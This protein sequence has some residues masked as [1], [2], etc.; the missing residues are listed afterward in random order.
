MCS[1]EREGGKWI[2][3]NANIN[4]RQMAA[5]FTLSIAKQIEAGL[6]ASGKFDGSHACLALATTGGNVLVHSPH[7]Q[8]KPD[9][10]MAEFDHVQNNDRRLAWTGELAELQIGNQVGAFSVNNGFLIVQVIFIVIEI[11]R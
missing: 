3:G 6:V 11:I 9:Q 7:R 4:R 5:S 1:G 8:P 10:R 2:S